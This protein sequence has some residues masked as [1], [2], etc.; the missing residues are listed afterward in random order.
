MT[1]PSLPD[2]LKDSSEPL[3]TDNEY[4]LVTIV[5]LELGT[6]YPLEFRWKYKDGT[7]S[8]IWS[9]VYNV[10]TQFATPPNTPQFLST[11]VTGGAGTITIEWNGN[12]SAGNA[13]TNI[14]RIEVW[15][16]EPPFDSTK[17][18]YQ[19]KTAFKTTIA[20]PAGSYTVAL[21][22]VTL[23][24]AYSSVSSAHTVNVTSVAAPVSAPTLPTGLSITTAPF[25]VT[26]NWDGTYSSSTFDGFKSIDIHVRG[27]D[28]GSTATAGFSTSTQVAS[29][30]V[31]STTNRQNISLDNL[32][33]A[34]SLASNDLAYTSPMYFYYIAR[35]IND[36]LYSVSGTPTYT[37]INSTSVNPSQ[38]NFVDLTSGVISVENL[39]AGNG[40][41]SSWLR[42]GTAGGSRIELSAVSDFT[43]GGNTVQKGLVAYSSGSTEV[44]NLDI[45]AGTLT[46]NGSG[47]FTGNLSI[48]SSNDIF[49]AEPATGIWLGNATYASAPFRVS[50]NGALFAESGTI[51]G[52]QLQS[53][54]LQNT[55]G[56]FKISSTNADPQI[57]VGSDASGHIRIS[58][59]Y[60]V[61]HYSSGTTL[62]GKFTLSPT[63]TSQISGWTI[64]ANSIF[65][66]NTI[67]D[68]T[69][70]NGYIAIG[71]GSSFFKAGDQG[72]QFGSETFG[73]APFRIGIDG[74]FTFGG[75]I[76]TGTTNS[77]TINGGQITLQVTGDV[78]SDNNNFAG[79]PTL[80]LNTSN[81]ITRGRR[82]LF[83]G[84][85]N[86]PTNPSSWNGSEGTWTNHNFTYTGTVKAGDVVMIY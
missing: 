28:L 69:G 66:G 45:D 80:T 29:L 65:K 67:L 82:F 35:N 34:L 78:E 68:S 11:N 63:G 48:G 86:V 56:T 52:W 51:A 46:I 14:D 10:T 8:E 6:S 61:A 70:T 40:Q 58:P 77:V 24:G 74:S 5:D 41:F 72:V 3:G 44:F 22:A 76:I 37:R 54:F 55:S 27:S 31:N 62:S 1:N 2:L 26:A 39:V 15:I 16:S 43:N 33:Q 4:F 9:A 7:S 84:T 79:D 64:G 60:G 36:A 32:R 59:T 57:Q 71:S 53:S 50:K 81:R 30:T 25:A 47:T 20:A 73:V 83:N 13:L 49:K 23:N 17:S 12:D 75:G 18:V 21:Y 42:T 19:S 85:S 38:A